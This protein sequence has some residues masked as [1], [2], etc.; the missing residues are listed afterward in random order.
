MFRMMPTIVETGAARP[1]FVRLASGWILMKYASGRR[2]RSVWMSPCV[3][4]Q[5]VWLF[6]L[7]Y[8]IMLNRTAVTMDSSANPFR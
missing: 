8:P 5:S 4:T 3:I 1:I 7:K 2:T 6:P